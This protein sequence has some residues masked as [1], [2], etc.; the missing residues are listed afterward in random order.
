MAELTTA[1]LSAIIENEKYGARSITGFEVFLPPFASFRRW[2]SDW[3][4]KDAAVLNGV[5]IKKNCEKIVFRARG[6][7]RS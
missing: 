6:N 1:L 7:K 3:A 2:V 4:R 5:V